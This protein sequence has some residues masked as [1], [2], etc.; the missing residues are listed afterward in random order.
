MRVRVPIEK[1]STADEHQRKIEK[2]YIK[3]N[4]QQNKKDLKFHN[5]DDD[6]KKKENETSELKELESL[7]DH[8]I[9]GA[10]KPNHPC[11][12]EILVEKQTCGLRQKPCEHEIYGI[13]RKK[14]EL[15]LFSLCMETE[16]LITFS[17]IYTLFLI[18]ILIFST[19]ILFIR[20][21]RR[22][23]SCST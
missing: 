4:A 2:L 1:D 17:F 13:P 21:K 19:S 5:E 23:L 14:L 12:N 15:T 10:A 9:L 11:F 6:S 22:C 8:E 16:P 7:S 18:H 3:F 20:T